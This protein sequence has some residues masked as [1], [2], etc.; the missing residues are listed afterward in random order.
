M[1]E[2]GIS[3]VPVINWDYGTKS[4]PVTQADVKHW[5][6]IEHIFDVLAAHL[7]EIDC[8]AWLKGVVTAV[9]EH[10]DDDTE[11]TITLALEWIARGHRDQAAARLGS[12][13]A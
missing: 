4:R 6:R 2:T 7:D 5:L 13:D 1:A 12:G 9:H 11:L 3:D 8:P 10:M